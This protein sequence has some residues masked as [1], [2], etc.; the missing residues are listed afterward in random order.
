MLELQHCGVG[1]EGG[2][3]VQALLQANQTLEV[4]DLRNNPFLPD[5]V[6][7]QVTGLLQERGSEA[8]SQV[9]AWRTE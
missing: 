1:T 8:A 3:S 7:G 5:T 9:S 4:I 2:A 6:V